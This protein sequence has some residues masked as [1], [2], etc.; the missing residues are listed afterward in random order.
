L[1]VD[2]QWDKIIN[3]PKL[4][5]VMELPRPRVLTEALMEAVYGYQLL[6]LEMQ[7]DLTGQR[8]L[9]DSTLLKPYRGLFITLQKV[10]SPNAVKAALLWLL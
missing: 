9:F 5:I 2:G 7:H 10:T 3:H 8:Q 4:H 1:A 6:A